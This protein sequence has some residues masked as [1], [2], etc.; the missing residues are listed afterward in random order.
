VPQPPGFKTRSLACLWALVVAALFLGGT[1]GSSWFG[2]Q[3]WRCS[4][5]QIIFSTHAVLPR[6]VWHPLALVQ[7]PVH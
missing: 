7:L 1:L 3:N 2:S 6:L 4:K 5:T